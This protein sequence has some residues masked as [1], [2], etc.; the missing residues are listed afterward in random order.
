MKTIKEIEREINAEIKSVTK[1]TTKSEASAVKRRLVFLRQCKIYLEAEP[2][3]EFIASEIAATKR[4]L[5]LI[6]THYEAWQVGKVLSKYNDPYNSFLTEMNYS[7]LKT[8]L[9]TLRFL[10]ED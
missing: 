4:K 6:P 8:Q 1:E 9:K 3:P 7:N 5:D 2:R 10:Y